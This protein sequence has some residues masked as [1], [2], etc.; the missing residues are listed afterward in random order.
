MAQINLCIIDRDLEYATAL[1]EA[2]AARTTG[3]SVKLVEAVGFYQDRPT[4][5]LA[6]TEQSQ[7]MLLVSDAECF[8]SIFERIPDATDICMIDAGLLADLKAPLPLGLPPVPILQLWD[9][10]SPL[11]QNDIPAVEKYS[12]CD[13]I[14]SQIRRIFAEKSGKS[15][16]L[17]IGGTNQ[18]NIEIL[19]FF[20]PEGGAG[21]SSIALGVAREL[22]RYRGKQV[23]YLSVEPFECPSLCAGSQPSSDIGLTEYLFHFLRGDMQRLEK[24]LKLTLMTD[25]YGVRRFKPIHGA[26]ALRELNQQDFMRFLQTIAADGEIDALLIDWGCDYDRFR[27]NAP[28]DGIAIIVARAGSMK[29]PDDPR[30]RQMIA[31]GIGFPGTTYFVLNQTETLEECGVAAGTKDDVICIADCAEDF[32]RTGNS[33]EIGLSNAFGLGIKALVD[34]ITGIEAGVGFRGNTLRIEG[35]EPYAFQRR[36]AGF[37]GLEQFD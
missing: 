14:L 26:N 36:A 10:R 22:S 33:L 20:S 31:E 5:I 35:G 3:F 13:C 30:W 6:D 12:G 25:A 18:G 34:Q 17:G 7:Q 8:K 29:A 24:L 32:N 11:S 37:A 15:I 27:L 1:A 23:F 4:S 28:S 2:I 9:G 16:A 21:T 19:H